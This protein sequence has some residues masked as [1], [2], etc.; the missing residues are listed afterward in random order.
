MFEKGYNKN[1]F[2]YHLIEI[3]LAAFKKKSICS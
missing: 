2:D 1:T 3:S